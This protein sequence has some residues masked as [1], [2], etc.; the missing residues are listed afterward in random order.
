M[1]KFVWTEDKIAQLTSLIADASFISQDRLTE[2]AG[3][4]EHTAR[5]VGSKIRQM[6]KTG[7]LSVEVQKAADAHK[8]AWTEDEEAGLVDFLNANAETM[9][10]NEIAVTFASGKFTSKQVQGKV[11]SLEMT[12]LVKKAEKVAAKRTYT[13]AEE[14]TFVEMANAEA[15]LEAI[16]EAMGRPL[17]SVRGKALSLHREGRIAGIPAQEHSNAQ[18]RKDFLE[19]L[20]V[21]AM[22]VEA[23]AEATGKNPRGIRNT[24]TR[25]GLDALDHKGAAKR[26][27]I[28]EKSD[29]A[30]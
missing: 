23:I 27:K 11:L 2:I 15:S 1:A 28:N 21:A 17:Q 7:L 22:T 4:V 19:G 9:T 13:D 8:S 12:D 20:D 29:K 18:V 30:E 6:V 25:R 10:Y 26:A 14:A 5:G 3:E 24:L 16:A